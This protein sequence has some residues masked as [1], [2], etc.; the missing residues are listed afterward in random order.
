M[1][2]SRTIAAV[3]SLAAAIVSL[4]AADFPRV[5]HGDE[6]KDGRPSVRWRGFNL[7]NMLVMGEKDR[8]PS[9]F[10][11]D[12]FRIIRDWGFNF[13]RLP[14]DYRFWIK[15]GE[16]KNWET[17]DERH[18]T[19]VD[20]AVKLGI[21]Y[22]IHVSLNMHRCPG[23]TVASPK[24]PTDL[25]SDDETLRVCCAHWA[26]FAKRYKG[27]PSEAL[28]FNLFNEPPPRVPDEK[29]GRVIKALVSAIRAEDP[30]RF[31]IADGANTASVPVWSAAGIE[32]VGQATRGYAPTR[33]THY[34]A[35]WAGHPSAKPVW[36]MPLDCPAGILAGPNKK[37]VHGRLELMDVPP[38]ELT[39]SFDRASDASTIRFVADGMRLKDI[40]IAPQTNNPVWRGVKYLDAHKVWQGTYLGCETFR[41]EKPVKKFSAWVVKGDWI[42]IS[43]VRLT[44]LDGARHVD[45]PC[46][47]SW[48]A[49][50][51]FRQRFAGWSEGF[52]SATPSGQPR[53]YPDAGREYLYRARLKKWDA[54]IEKGVFCFAGEF[55]VWKRTSHDVT[56]RIMEDY[57]KLWKER[58][59]GWALWNL[60]GGC[61]VLDSGRSDV[62]YEDFRGY[63]LD[64]KMLELL[65]RY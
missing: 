2:H 42:Q 39:I 32:G 7:V 51:D 19:Y 6:V 55:G 59:M 18:L 48:R 58:N 36:P 13:V 38:C 5:K 8:N 45:L 52:R 3:L 27:I 12:D 25:F 28:S 21:K 11:E 35:P 34:M 41:F 50:R 63:K 56:L 4:Q 9:P 23:H 64:R 46:E 16:R 31:I 20:R 49:P 60:R 14:M 24:E 61:G 44:S 1:I 40:S 10:K 37:G 22:G 29:Y 62:E 53:T 15:G 30:T 26:M 54:L 17:F 65:Q 47:T 57:L 33:V 43:D